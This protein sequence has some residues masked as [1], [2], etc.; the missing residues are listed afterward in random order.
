MRRYRK[1]IVLV[2]VLVLVLVAGF[3]APR[4]AIT[5]PSSLQQISSDPFTNPTSQHETEVEPDTFA[6]GDTIVAA[7]QAGRFLNSGA[8]SIGWATST[9]GGETWTSGF[10]PELT[11][12]ST[13]AGPF[14][15][16]SDPSVAYDVTH[17][18]WLISSLVLTGTDFTNF[19]TALVVSRSPDGMTWG[20]PVTVSPQTGSF[21]HDKNWIVCDNGSA[22][23]FAG[24]CYISWTA[25][26]SGQILTSTSPDG[27]LTWGPAEAAADL[28]TGQGTQPVV[29]PD[30][31][32]V[33]VFKTF[34]DKISAIRSTDGGASFSAKELVSPVLNHTPTDMRALP[35]PS[36]EVDGGGRLY[37]VWHDCKF[38]PG[39]PANDLVMS[40][41]TDGIAWSAVTR[42]PI[43][44]TDSGID[45][46]I[47][48]LGVDPSTE[49]AETRLALAFYFFPDASCTF[50]TCELNV[51]YI[52]SGNGGASWSSSRQLNEVPMSLSWIADT[53]LGRMVGDYISTSFV[54]DGVAVPVFAL[55]FEPTS[56]T[57][58]EAMY[59]IRI[60]TSEVEIDIKPGSDPNSI[61]TR[62]A[63]V[64]PVAILSSV[65]FD[66]PTQVDKTSLTFGRTGDEESLARCPKSAE[67]A[68]GDG[69]LDQVCLFR[70]KDAAFQAGDTEG[71]LRGQTVDGVPLEGRDAVR[72]VN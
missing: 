37:A 63:G 51:G 43:D 55:A 33:I 58:D 47:P 5:G 16:A 25:L 28:A 13:P 53:T 42:I 14:D 41:S 18:V 60:E 49:G 29:R 4:G 21:S 31:T 71:V 57:F 54:N 19:D 24:R 8:S 62:N 15:R 39:C 17:G 56:S 10:L 40:T 64:I 3:A 72:I 44:A 69:L 46:F 22:S 27:G 68:N 30:G 23:P 65:E 35:F 48:G 9:D 67:D 45:H 59:A 70:T 12:F 6:F 34:D 26:P 1:V 32:V 11:V 7:F 61:S 66:A 36:V 38:R 52:S 20:A 2:S 50:V